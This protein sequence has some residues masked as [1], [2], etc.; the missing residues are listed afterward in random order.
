MRVVLLTS[1]VAA[2]SGVTLYN[3][4]NAG[5]ALDAVEKALANIVSSPHLT[6]TQLLQAKQVAAD[7]EKT[8]EELESPAG[9]KLS[10]AQRGAKVTASIKELQDL[11][12]NWEK[13][14]QSTIDSKKADL[15][16]QL[17][18]KEAEL[19][20][21]QKMLKVINLE[22]KLA[23]KKLALQKLIDM[24]N[25]KESAAAATAKQAEV[26]KVINAS[27]SLKDAKSLKT[28]TSYLDGRVKDLTS[29][30]AKLDASEKKREGEIEA[31]VSV[32]APVKDDKDPLAKGQGVLKM[33]LKKEHR[34]FE[35]NRATL[36]AELKEMHQ[37]QESIKKGDVAGLTKVMTQMQG[38]MKSLEAKSQ[39]FLY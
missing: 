22:K 8:V 6:K 27:K 36:L 26:A 24:K 32:K 5:V 20:K 34:Q 15:E 2:C 30:M 13:T 17:K 28:V 25:A 35:K 11:Q 1:I 16:K 12:E 29:T 33:L 14:A 37:A 19:A 39:K 4:P 21:D 10:Q 3:P 38:E 18:D 9:K 23:E 7:V 31:L